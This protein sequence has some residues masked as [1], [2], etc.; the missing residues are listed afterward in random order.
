M[1]RVVC[2]RVE[3]VVINLFQV[4]FAEAIHDPEAMNTYS[5]AAMP[6]SARAN[7]KRSCV[8]RE[9]TGR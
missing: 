5:A 2:G 4:I 8:R 7:H 1:Q 6:G 9:S 3:C